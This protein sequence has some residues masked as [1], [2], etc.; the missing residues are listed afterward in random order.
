LDNLTEEIKEI[1][2]ASGLYG[3]YEGNEK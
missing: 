2:I 1:L 3:Y